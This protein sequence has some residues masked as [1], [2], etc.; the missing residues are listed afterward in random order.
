MDNET[1]EKIDRVLELVEENNELLHKMH[2]SARFAFFIRVAYWTILILLSLGAFYFIQPY[3]EKIFSITSDARSDLS[4][5]S[6]T[7]NTIT[8]TLKKIGN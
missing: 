3:I 7:A 6:K 2:R 1:R 5:I 8:N 4:D